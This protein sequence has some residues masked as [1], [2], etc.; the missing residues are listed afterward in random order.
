VLSGKSTE[1]NQVDVSKSIRLLLVG[2]IA[3][4]LFGPELVRDSLLC[5]SS[6]LP[7]RR[8]IAHNEE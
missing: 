5:G 8:S 2:L 6:S 7:V 1:A 3:L 4:R